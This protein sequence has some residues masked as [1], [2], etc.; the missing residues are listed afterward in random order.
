M[1]EIHFHSLP[2]PTDALV[3]LGGTEVRLRVTLSYFVEPN[4]G[5]RGWVRRYAYASHGLRF[6]VRRATESNDDFRKRLNA[7]ARAEDEKRPTSASDA[8]SW[9]FGP[10]YR[11]SGSLHSDIWMGTAADLAQRGAIA[12]YP[13]S[14][15]WKELKSRDR[16]QRGA[17]YALW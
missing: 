15:W 5:S 8:Q 3:Q 11:V 9:F 4:P 1:R 13:V 14:G 10:D 7:L 6:D 12:V 16:S 17:P 2:W